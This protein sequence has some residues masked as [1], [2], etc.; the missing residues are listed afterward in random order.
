MVSKFRDSLYGLIGTDGT[1]LSSPDAPS[2]ILAV[3]GG[4][5]SMCMAHLFSSIFY[6]NMA[7]ATVPSA[8]PP[9]LQIECNI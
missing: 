3:S 9:I 6:S 2:V 4:I 7:I 5:D 1:H 8:G